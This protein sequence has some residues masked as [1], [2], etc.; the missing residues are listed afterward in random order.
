MEIGTSLKINMIIALFLTIVSEGIFSLVIINFLKFPVIFSIIFLLILWLIQWLISP[1]LVERNSVEVTRDDPSYGWVYE[2]VENV[3]RRAG[4]KT[5]RVFL[6]DEPYPNAFAY[7]NYVTGKRIGITI[8]LLQ[9]LT[10]EELE[11]V[12]GHELGHIKH[13]DVEIGLAIGL[14][15]SIL[16]FISNILLTV[17]W[18][19]LIFA[20]DEF[21]ILV[22]L[23]MLAIGGVLF[24]ITFFLQLFVLWFNRLRESFADYF[25]YELF[26]ERAWNLAKALAKIEIYMQNIR[27][28]PFRGIIV[29]IPPTKVKESDPDL[30]IEDLLREKT[31]IFS[32]ILS[33]HPHPAKRIKM[34]Y[35]LTKPMIF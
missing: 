13:N 1:Y 26:R 19:T 28:D 15:P 2:L 8:P 10:T 25:S 34:I 14:I 23:T 30:L 6:V 21:D 9:I 5:P 11:S 32:D 33:T 17:G 3:A 20:V 24:V 27:L 18:A 7:G 4:I 29:T 35:K 16:G 12:I 31:N 22:G